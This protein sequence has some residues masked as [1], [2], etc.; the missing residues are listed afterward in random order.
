MT[1]IKITLMNQEF[2]WKYRKNIPPLYSDNGETALDECWWLKSASSMQYGV[3]VVDKYGEVYNHH[4]RYEPTGVRP[5]VVLE[6][7]A[8]DLLFWSKPEILIGSKI[9]YGRYKWTVL[10]QEDGVVYAL[11][12]RLIAKRRFDA[13]TNIWVNSELK[14]WLETEGIKGISGCEN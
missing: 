3:E 12:D 14:S 4:C 8:S 13:E 9:E 11:C 7:N 10:D 5:V 6:L 2:F 1:L